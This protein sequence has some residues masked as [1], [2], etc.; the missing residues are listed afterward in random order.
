MVECG[1]LVATQLYSNDL[2][3]EFIVTPSIKEEELDFN[4]DDDMNHDLPELDE[5]DIDTNDR[6]RKTKRKRSNAK[7]TADD[8]AANDT[9][10]TRKSSQQKLGKSKPKTVEIKFKRKVPKVSTDIAQL[11]N[12]CWFYCDI[13]GMKS[14][15]RE[16]LE[17]HLRRDHKMK[18]N[19]YLCPDC[20]KWFIDRYYERHLAVHKQQHICQ[21]C[22]NSFQNAH[23][24]RRHIRD[25]HDK[26]RKTCE[27]GCPLTGKFLSCM[28]LNQLHFKCDTCG[29]RYK[30]QTNLDHHQLSHLPEDQRPKKKHRVLEPK[31][32]FY[33]AI[34]QYCGK[35]SKN[36]SAEI[37]H[38]RT[39]TG[40]KPY[41]CKV[42][43]NRFQTSLTY[44]N[45]SFLHTGEKPHKCETCGMRFR[46]QTHL[47]THRRV[48]TGEKPYKCPYCD[49]AFALKGNLTPHIRLHTGETPFKC[50]QCEQSFMDLNGLK[51][52]RRKMHAV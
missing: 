47:V 50:D 38:L 5:L 13:C 19:R 49:K 4:L 46:Q 20:N 40:E 23:N 9:D 6:E 2:K 39:H 21:L 18:R 43:G 15:I 16:R 31:T 10:R 1:S 36:R 30:T 24:L 12:S 11:T 7:Y 25:M 44:R 33:Q 52:H 37:A 35:L 8:L 26:I 27:Y 17:E 48:H 32:K 22:S 41:E 34:C 3:T 45:H 51:R 14:R 28:H 42:C 29:I